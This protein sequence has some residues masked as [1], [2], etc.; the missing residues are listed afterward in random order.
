VAKDAVQAW[1]WLDLAA[2]AGEAD[3]AKNR[4]A[5]A[6]TMTA[7]QIADARK[8]V[9]KWKADQVDSQPFGLFTK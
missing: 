5:V 9:E 2:S 4:D 3:A 7:A 1:Q 8:L 6:A